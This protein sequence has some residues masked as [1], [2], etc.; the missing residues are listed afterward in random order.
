[1]ALMRAIIHAI[2]FAAACAAAAPA[3]AQAAGS[4]PA[5]CVAAP[6]E[7]E[8]RARMGQAALDS[9]QAFHGIGRA[10]EDELREAA[11]A[12]GISEPAGIVL[13]ERNNQRTGAGRVW[14]FRSN[15]P[16][17]LS[18]TVMARHAELLAR[19]PGRVGPINLR[20]DPLEG[21]DSVTFECMP[22]LL[23]PE[24]F[25]RDLRRISTSSSTP[26]G[27][28]GRTVTLHVKMLV[29]REGEVAYAELERPSTHRDVNRELLQVMRRLRFTPASIQNVPMDVWVEQSVEVD[30]PSQ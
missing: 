26:G 15:V 16:D 21:P 8:G 1:M 2:L 24:A 7:A 9:Q 29:T 22:V 12:A 10:L 20:L 4:L 11:R 14:S 27:G 30:V 6:S 18:R 25:R 28:T 17:A 3:H 13:V 23:N 19:W 5:N